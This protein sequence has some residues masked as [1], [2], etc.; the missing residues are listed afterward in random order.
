MRKCARCNLPETFE[1]IEFGEDGVCNIC[2]A[3][4]QKISEDW[5]RKKLDLDA[6]IEQYRGK[7][8][9]DCIVPFSGG[10]DSTFALW[11]LVHHYKIK[12]LVVRYDHGFMRPGVL[13]NMERT[14]KKLGVDAISYTG[15]WK[16]IKRIMLEALIRR[17][18]FCITCHWGCFAF[19]MHMALKFQTPLVFWGE[20]STDYTAYFSM[21]EVE[22]VDETR[23]DRFVNMGIS[24][25][26]MAGMIKHDTE[27]DYRDLKMWTYPKRADL[28]KLG[29]RS[30]CLGSYIK[31]DVREQVKIIEKELGWQGDA[32]EG[33][34]RW[35]WPYDKI[36]CSMQGVR[37]YLK[38]LKRGYSR[39]SQNCA[40]DLRNGRI[41]KEDAETLSKNEGWRPPSLDLFLEYVGITEDEFNEYVRATVVA[42]HVPDFNRMKGD[43]PHDFKEWYREQRGASA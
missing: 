2:C 16:L 1:T 17:G 28:A 26:D 12:P 31:W 27:F 7:Y 40:I 8:D 10:K 9:Y 3:H 25:E 42:P 18:D 21:N 34:P 6:L 38:F 24:A 19:P 35:Q 43:A 20:R 37:D 29:V 36:E 23:F 33:M 14:L 13:K 30:V 15:N 4:E 11:Y 32:V 39:I 41:S 5:D 22:E